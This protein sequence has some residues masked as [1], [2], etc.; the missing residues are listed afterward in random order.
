MWHLQV[1]S[2]IQLPIRAEPNHEI[3]LP[4]HKADRASASIGITRGVVCTDRPRASHRYPGP[5]EDGPG[6]ALTDV[7]AKTRQP[8]SVTISNRQDTIQRTRW[9]RSG[10]A[11]RPVPRSS[12]QARN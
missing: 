10:A 9:D 5:D 3:G 6:W 2:R 8:R 11:D 4:G 12:A 7:R 1:G